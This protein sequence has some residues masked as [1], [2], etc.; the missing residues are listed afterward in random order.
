MLYLNDIIHF[1]QDHSSIQDSFVVQEWLSLQ[2][3]IKLT[4]WPPQVPD[5]NLI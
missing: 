1:Q 4:D 3:D 5:T 2:A